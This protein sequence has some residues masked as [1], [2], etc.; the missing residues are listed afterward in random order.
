PRCGAYEPQVRAALG[1]A[2]VP[3]KPAEAETACQEQVHGGLR[4]QLVYQN[5]SGIIDY[6]SMKYFLPS[7]LVSAGLVLAQSK[8]AAPQLEHVFDLH[9][10]LGKP[11]DVGKTGPAG[12]R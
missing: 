1:L 9:L 2:R 10:Q 5:P 6:L 8:P 4:C 11:T 3:Q 12:N 7:L